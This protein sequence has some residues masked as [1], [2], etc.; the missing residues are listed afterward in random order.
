MGC[1]AKSPAVLYCS[2]CGND[3][4]G[5]PALEDTLVSWRA[6]EKQPLMLFPTESRS[7]QTEVHT[8]YVRQTRKRQT[9]TQ[10]AFL[11][12]SKNYHNPLH[13]P[14]WAQ[15][16]LVRGLRH[17]RGFRRPV[18]VPCGAG[19]TLPDPRRT[20]RTG[21]PRLPRI[22]WT[23]RSLQ[24]PPFPPSLPLRARP[25]HGGLA[26]YPAAK[27]AR[28]RPP[29]AAASMMHRGGTRSSRVVRR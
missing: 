28:S 10:H 23:S 15:P 21:C 8:V 27:E 20:C 22:D 24:L 6:G 2:R 16:R 14:S 9:Q 26:A 17:T 5:T 4:P 13:N 11:Q 18:V 19:P 3:R 12:D 29:T 1:G 25:R 7:N